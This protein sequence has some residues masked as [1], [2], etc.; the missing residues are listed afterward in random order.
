MKDFDNME[1]CI[2]FFL[3]IDFLCR[4]FICVVKLEMYVFIQLFRC[5]QDSVLGQFFFSSRVLLV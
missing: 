1:F 5:G 3:G 4:H 2:S